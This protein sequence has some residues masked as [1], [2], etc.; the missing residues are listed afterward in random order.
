MCGVLASGPCAAALH[1]QQ[2]ALPGWGLRARGLL[3]QGAPKV[4]EMVHSTGSGKAAKSARVQLTG[5]TNGT[6][7]VVERQAGAK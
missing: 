4:S 2:S 1:I 7:F 6:P 5:L 3:P